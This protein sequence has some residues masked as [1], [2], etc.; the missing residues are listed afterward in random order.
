[1]KWYS[2]VWFIQ[3]SD[4][5]IDWLI[6][7]THCNWLCRKSRTSI[8]ADRRCT[9]LGTRS[10]TS[11]RR[12]Y[13]AGTLDSPSGDWKRGNGWE[14]KIKFFTR[15]FY[16][17]YLVKSGVEIWRA[18]VRHFLPRG[19]RRNPAVPPVGTWNSC[20]VWCGS[21]DSRGRPR[22]DW[23]TPGPF[24]PEN[25]VAADQTRTGWTRWHRDYCPPVK[26]PIC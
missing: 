14:M 25:R 21:R 12:E 20:R 2:V 13:N 6:L 22:S 23:G 11:C 16:C 26:E 9:V 18:K 8:G 5:L 10:C 7:L 3:S 1:M 4:R 24:P 15:L 19:L 17:S